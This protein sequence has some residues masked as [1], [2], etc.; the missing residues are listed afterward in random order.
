VILGRAGINK[1]ISKAQGAFALV[2]V[3]HSSRCAIEIVILSDKLMLPAS[4]LPPSPQW[5]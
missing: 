1:L 4:P 3:T 5:H 2:L